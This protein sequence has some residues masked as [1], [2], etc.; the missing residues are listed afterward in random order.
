MQC[1]KLAV[2]PPIQRDDMP[3][4]LASLMYNNTRHHDGI[5]PPLLNTEGALVASRRL[6]QWMRYEKGKR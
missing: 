2:M 3:T 4:L 1:S 5:N 6:C